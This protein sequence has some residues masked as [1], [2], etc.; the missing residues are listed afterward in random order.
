MEAAKEVPV[1]DSGDEELE[2]DNTADV[3]KDPSKKKKKKR[4]GKKPGKILIGASI[5]SYK[6]LNP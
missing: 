2:D 5:S 3:V 1:V 4:R 6:L